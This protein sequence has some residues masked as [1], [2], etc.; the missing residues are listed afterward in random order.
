MAKSQGIHRVAGGKQRREKRKKPGAG[1]GLA[2]ILATLFWLG[3]I[4]WIWAV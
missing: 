4:A 3:I 2:V 1:L